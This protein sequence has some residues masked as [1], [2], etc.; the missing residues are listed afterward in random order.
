MFT[1]REF[2]K[3]GKLR[4]DSRL[5]ESRSVARCRLEECRA[6]CCGHGV[7]VDSAHAA[8][9]VQEAELVKPYMPADRRDVDGWFD[10]LVESDTNFPSGYRVGS[11]VIPDLQ[12]VAHTRCVFLRSDN[13]CALQVASI[14]QGRHPWDLKPFFCALYPIVVRG[15]AVQLDDENDIYA[16]GGTC[17]RAELV[18]APLYELFK[19]E[20]I[21]ALGH[22][23]YGQLCLK[24]SAHM[25]VAR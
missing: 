22:E 8:R 14:A 5:I 19:D 21:L 15:D 12:H 20:L 18:Y 11:K 17:Q 10:D 3:V 4:V 9:I 7:Y 23:G 2:I 6:S 24:A 16:L 13:H 1:V 25:G